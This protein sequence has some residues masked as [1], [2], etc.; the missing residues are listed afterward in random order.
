VTVGATEGLFVCLKAMM[1]PGD[2]VL[3]FNPA[4]PWYINTARVAGATP[5]LVEL[6]GPDFAPDMEEIEKAI[7]PKTRVLLLNTPHNPCGHCYT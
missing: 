6:H 2:E 1:D 7:T 4:Y 5:V 3:M